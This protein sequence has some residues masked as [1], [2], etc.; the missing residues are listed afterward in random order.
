MW[1]SEE[2]DPTIKDNKVYNGLQG[3]IYV[4]KHGRGLIQGNDIYG[5]Q[6]AGIQIKTK[7]NP[8]IR[9]NK[10]H[11]GCHGGIYIHE[12]GFGTIE[13]NEIFGNELAAIWITTQSKPII[14]NNTIHSGKQVIFYSRSFKKSVRSK[15]SIC[16]RTA[17]HIS[18]L[19]GP[20]IESLL[21]SI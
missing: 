21:L 8:L 15:C 11:S 18:S 9:Q 19:I 16:W 4:F 2:S 14:R 20:D 10:I 1:I 5:N 17:A 13:H 12:K 6:L 7:S 3:G